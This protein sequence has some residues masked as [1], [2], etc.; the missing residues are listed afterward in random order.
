MVKRQQIKRTYIIYLKFEPV[1]VLALLRRAEVGLTLW[2]YNR[3]G[4]QGKIKSSA[5][6]VIIFA[7]IDCWGEAIF[8][9]GS[10]K[11]L[12]LNWTIGEEVGSIITHRT[13]NKLRQG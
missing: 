6:S 7:S 13:D 9:A 2:I 1:I 8:V 4:L 3:L 11:L 10:V 5:I 12:Y